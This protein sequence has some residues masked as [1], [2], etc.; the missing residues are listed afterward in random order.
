MYNELTNL[1]PSKRQSVLTHD[2]F[3]RLGVVGVVLLITLTFIAAILLIPAYVFL[4]QN[5]GAK[6]ARLAS[7]ESTLSSTNETALSVRLTALTEDVA[8]LTA[9]ASAPSAS[10]IIR[11]MLAVPHSGIALSGL[12][13]T[14]VSGKVPETLALFGVAATR[15][16]LRA[17]QLALQGAPS[18]LSATLPVSAYANDTNIIFTITVTFSS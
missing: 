14:P 1:L 6:A 16:A 7:I 9:L 3:L 18:V 13:Y 4:Q 5:A 15:D 11:T 8:T 17:Y 2:Y 12:T 10:A